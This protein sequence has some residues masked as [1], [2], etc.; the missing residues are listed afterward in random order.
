MVL[1]AAGQRASVEENGAGADFST[2]VQA[3]YLP[4]PHPRGIWANDAWI[5]LDA[6]ATGNGRGLRSPDD[7]AFR[8]SDMD[9]LAASGVE[10]CTH[11]TGLSVQ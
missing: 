11:Y 1:R 3:K 6:K 4:I 8:E 9:D 7:S 5:D 2:F 10:D